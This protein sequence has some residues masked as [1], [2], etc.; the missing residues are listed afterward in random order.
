MFENQI[1]LGADLVRFLIINSNCRVITPDV[2]AGSEQF[3]L[4]HPHLAK[5]ALPLLKN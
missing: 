5:P 2:G 3:L 1:L 4:H